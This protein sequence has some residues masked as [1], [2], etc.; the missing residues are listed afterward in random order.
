MDY[1]VYRRNNDNKRVESS[2]R[3][4]HTSSSVLT[5]C[6]LCRR[7]QLSAHLMGLPKR[8]KRRNRTQRLGVQPRSHT[9]AWQLSVELF[10]LVPMANGNEPD[11]AFTTSNATLTTCVYRTVI[12]PFPSYQHRPS[13]FRHDVPVKSTQCSSLPRWNFRKT[14]P[15]PDAPDIDDA[16]NQF[17][18]TIIRIAKRHI[19]RGNRK[20]YI[21]RWDNECD[22]LAERHHAAT[23]EH[24]IQD[25]A[26]AL[27]EH[28]DTKQQERCVETVQAIHFTHSSRKEQHTSSA[29]LPLP[30][31]PF[32]P[33]IRQKKNVHI[34]L[35]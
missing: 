35:L 23:S 32:P 24:D 14:L 9:S 1:C 2:E 29:P 28:L 3:A 15:E 5:S 22:E 33:I 30:P 4:L 7:L 17:T 11:L 25:T 16:Y 19:P 6:Y 10:S 12:E 34:I 8:Y 31:S 21:P 20:I 13:L 26:T 18:P 27:P